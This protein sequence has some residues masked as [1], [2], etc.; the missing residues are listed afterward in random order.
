MI[1]VR[2]EGPC[3]WQ[4]YTLNETLHIHPRTHTH[5]EYI[6]QLVLTIVADP[7][8]I[9]NGVAEFD[10]P[11]SWI[12]TH[13]GLRP[14]PCEL[15]EDRRMG[16]Q[17]STDCDHFSCKS[18]QVTAITHT[19]HTYA[20]IGTHENARETYGRTLANFVNAIYT[21]RSDCMIGIDIFDYKSNRMRSVCVNAANRKTIL[22]SE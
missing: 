20:S 16:S 18:T 9:Y 14:A 12:V 1:A 17:N 19:H 15:C 11:L 2:N 3:R 5:A 22:W 7:T 6:T 10:G 4:C 13:R 8:R 21:V